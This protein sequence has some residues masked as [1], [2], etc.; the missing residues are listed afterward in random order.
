MTNEASRVDV[1][2]PVNEPS[3]RDPALHFLQAVN[4]QYKDSAE[5]ER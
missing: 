2:F 4:K 5:R 1:V 3:S